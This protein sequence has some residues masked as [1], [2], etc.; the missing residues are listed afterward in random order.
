V[1]LLLPETKT[2][3]Y[4]TADRPYFEAKFKELCP[5]CKVIYGNANQDAAS[6]QQQAEAAI[7]NRARVL[8]LDPVDSSAAAA[9]TSKA[10]SQGVPVVSYDRLIVNSDGVAAYISFDNEKV[11]EFQARSLV[12]ALKGSRTH[13]S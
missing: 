10:K 7:T 9:M 5:N 11:G 13:R 3:R 1:A 4:E 6:Q 2:T 8:V 12:D